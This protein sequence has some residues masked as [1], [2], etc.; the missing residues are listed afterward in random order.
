[1]PDQKPAKIVKLLKAFVKKRCPDAK[2]VAEGALE[3]YRGLTSGPLA[4]AVSDA[5]Q[6]GFGKRPV[7][8]REGGSIGANDRQGA[9]GQ[10]RQII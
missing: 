2:L 4:D 8:V 5:V 1:M 9:F 6:F 7:F 10:G 3:P